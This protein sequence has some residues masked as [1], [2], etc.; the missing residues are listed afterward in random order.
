M[1]EVEG[2]GRHKIIDH[3]TRLADADMELFKKQ[4]APRLCAFFAYMKDCGYIG[5]TK[6]S[7]FPECTTEASGSPSFDESPLFKLWAQDHKIL[8]GKRIHNESVNANNLL[9]KHLVMMHE[10]DSGEAFTQLAIERGT[11]INQQERME[12]VRHQFL[13]A[14]AQK[15]AGIQKEL[16][17]L[18][19][20]TNARGRLENIESELRGQDIRPSEV[21]ENPQKAIRDNTAALRKINGGLPIPLYEIKPL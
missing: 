20:F 8:V 5:H 10:R 19:P 2:S 7:E 14:T 6:R 4:I 16:G 21:F 3:A 1:S 9:M 13:I 11:Q 12:Q 17:I 18:K 15:V